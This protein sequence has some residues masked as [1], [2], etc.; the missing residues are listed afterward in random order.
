MLLEVKKISKS[1]KKGG[2]KAVSG[3][4]F[5]M[6]A[7]KTLGVVG[8]SGCGKSTL[9]KLILRLLAC[10]E[11]VIYF[12]GTR[13]DFLPENKLKDFRKKVQIVFQD[14]ILSLD[15]RMKI[16]DSLRE[17]FVLFGEPKNSADQ[18]IKELLDSVGLSER[19]L[20]RYPHELSGGECQRVA[21]ARALSQKPKLL[22]CDE[23]V[24]SLD[25]VT[26]IQVL[27]LFLKLQKEQGLSLL[28]VSHDRRVVDHMSHEILVM[29]E[30][31]LV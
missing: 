16:V 1:F 6:E 14:P 29:K 4:S 26:K 24:S 2:V 9:L 25:A 5:S 17:P 7:G 27:N 28:F 20:K 31:V 19:F 3:A 21:I 8:A 11:G 23:V 10:D 18:K 13:I 22:L 15:P 30:G 12:E